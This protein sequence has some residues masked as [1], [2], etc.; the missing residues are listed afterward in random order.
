VERVEG[1]QRLEREIRDARRGLSDEVIRRVG[2]NG[3][4]A[5]SSRRFMKA[6]AVSRIMPQ[7][8]LPQILPPSILKISTRPPKKKQRG[9]ASTLLERLAK[10]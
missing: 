1:A 7:E 3:L 9:L 2:Q 5:G 4:I 10:L 8:E 6:M